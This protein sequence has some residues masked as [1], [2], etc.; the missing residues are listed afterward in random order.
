MGQILT[1]FNYTFT[2]WLS[3]TFF[4]TITSDQGVV[5]DHRWKQGLKAEP[6]VLYVDKNR[7]FLE[8]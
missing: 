8:I 2:S 3:S 6:I 4:L 1:A 7:H 5:H